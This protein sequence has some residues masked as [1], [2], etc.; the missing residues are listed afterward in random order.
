MRN[1]NFCTQAMTIQGT[2]LEVAREQPRYAR[3]KVEHS[4]NSYHTSV[5]LM[6][7]KQHMKLGNLA[8]EAINQVILHKILEHIKQDAQA[9]VNAQSKGEIERM[10]DP[11]FSEVSRGWRLLIENHPLTTTYTHGLGDLLNS[12]VGPN[13]RMR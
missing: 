7:V 3:G 11:Y 2:L 6:L 8:R 1:L 13:L 9:N 12:S 10:L 5:L 4:S